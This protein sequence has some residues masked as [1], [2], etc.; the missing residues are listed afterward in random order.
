MER[1][2]NVRKKERGWKK[3]IE[4]IFSLVKEMAGP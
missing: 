3:T 2:K 1:M 4:E